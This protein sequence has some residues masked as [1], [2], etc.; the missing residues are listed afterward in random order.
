MCLNNLFCLCVCLWVG[1]CVHD[2]NLQPVSKS[3]VLFVV[4]L[5]F[6]YS[7]IMIQN[8]QKS[9]EKDLNH[10]RSQPGVNNLNITKNQQNYNIIYIFICTEQPSKK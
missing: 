2:A 10:K 5:L 9:H 3:F 6:M 8:N 1:V 7:F 4:V